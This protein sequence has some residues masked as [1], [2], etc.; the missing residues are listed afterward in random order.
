MAGV[1]TAPWLIAAT[2]A[3]AWLVFAP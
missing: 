1:R 3:L 2:L